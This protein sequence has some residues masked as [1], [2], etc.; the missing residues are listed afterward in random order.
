MVNDRPEHLAGY[1]ARDYEVVDYQLY[2]LLG[3]E[4]QFRGPEPQ[5]AEGEYFSCLG[6]A[7]TFG[8]FTEQPY[9]AL[10]QKQMGTTA[11]NLGYGGAGPRFF[12]RHPELLEI[13]NQGKFAIVQIM[14][15]RSEDNSR[16]ESR[17]LERLTR[18]S[19]GKQMSADAAWRSVLEFRYAW[20]RL[21]FGQGL[22]R[23][24]CR[25]YGRADAKRLLR[26]TRKHW[27]N[28]YTELLSAIRVPK[29]LLWF[30][31]RSPDFHESFDDLQHFMGPYPQF[32]TREMVEAIVD[33]AEDYVECIT[34]Q[35]SPQKLLSRFD[36]SPVEVDLSRDR[37]DFAGQIWTH[38]KYYP[39]PEM[40]QD[41]ATCLLAMLSERW[42]N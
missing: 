12:N 23:Q 3:T 33:Q 7:Q 30:S 34:D 37:D 25:L 16:F 18:R 19:N 36:S 39:S 42:G 38:N 2:Q 26:E 20:R 15:G 32:V 40:H 14:S 41:A 9:P 28:S 6:A 27:L 13:V 21:P 24:F 22:A 1:Q 35:G 17:G 5:L 11:L 31:K 4:L 29:I 8:C 10:L